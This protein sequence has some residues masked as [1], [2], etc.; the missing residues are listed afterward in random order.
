MRADTAPT[1]A[2]V[3]FFQNPTPACQHEERAQTCRYTKFSQKKNRGCSVWR[4]INTCEPTFL[5]PC[6]T[7]THT[8]KCS[9]Y[10][11][12]QTPMC[13]CFAVL[14][15]M[16]LRVCIVYACMPRP[17]FGATKI[18]DVPVIFLRINIKTRVHAYNSSFAVSFPAVLFSKFSPF[19]SCGA[20]ALFKIPT[21]ERA[22][23]LAATPTT[24][25]RDVVIPLSAVCR[26]SSAFKK[27]GG[28][29]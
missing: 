2:F 23:G 13:R 7:Y 3:G 26:Y 19:C 27:L 18:Q 10:K 11:S 17:P 8:Y 21:H 9:R 20:G 28:P 16:I 15:Q 24:G 14:V 25:E 29:G 4:T 12:E 1:P 5:N 6:C 22:V